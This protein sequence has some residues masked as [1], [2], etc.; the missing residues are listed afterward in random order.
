MTIN[1]EINQNIYNVF[2]FYICDEEIVE[3]D[4]LK[5]SSITIRN[6]GSTKLRVY[7]KES[8][9]SFY[10]EGSWVDN[11]KS[12]SNTI[13]DWYFSDE[14]KANCKYEELVEQATRRNAEVEKRKEAN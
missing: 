5:I 14:D 2:T 4:K 8:K 12:C 9:K 1:F 13:E 10:I 3:I 11:N 6:D 7:R